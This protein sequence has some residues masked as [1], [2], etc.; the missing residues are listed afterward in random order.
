LRF[1]TDAEFIQ[2]NAD[3]LD[4]IDAN[5]FAGLTLQGFYNE[6]V[7]PDHEIFSKNELDMSIGTRLN[8][9]ASDRINTQ[10]NFE[11]GLRKPLEEL[12]YFQAEHP[13]RYYGMAGLTLYY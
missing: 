2:G 10:F 13:I 12:Q 6:V 9:K 11:L 1:T 5:D 8:F 3:Y 4:N 7:H